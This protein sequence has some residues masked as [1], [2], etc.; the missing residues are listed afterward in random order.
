VGQLA[1]GIFV[2]SLAAEESDDWG[3]ICP[4]EFAQRFPSIWRAAVRFADKEPTSGVEC[5]FSGH[6]INASERI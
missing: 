6:E 5:L 4:A 2:T 1:R 3:I